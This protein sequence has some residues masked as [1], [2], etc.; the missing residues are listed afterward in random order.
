MINP[1]KITIK[2][3]KELLAPYG[4]ELSAW[5]FAKGGEVNVNLIVS[6][7][8]KKYFVKIAVYRNDNDARFQVEL[9]EYL[10][11]KKFSLPKLLRTKTGK[12]FVYFKKKPVFVYEFIE[13]KNINLNDARNRRLV[14]ADIIKMQKLLKDFKPKH[15]FVKHVN[16]IEHERKWLKR[17]NK[18]YLFKPWDEMEAELGTINYSELREQVIHGDLQS[19]NILIDKKGKLW[20]IDFDEARLDYLLYDVVVFITQSI[21][22]GRGISLK[23]A[24]EYIQFFQK[25]YKLSN[26]DFNIIRIMANRRLFTKIIFFENKIYKGLGDKAQNKRNLSLTQDRYQDFVQKQHLFSLLNKN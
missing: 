13:G 22:H 26:K 5:C 10:H 9:N 24:Q 23:R 18:K 17:I 2:D 14:L 4:I 8:E 19:Q 7:K 1:S 15:L 12:F 16:E 20:F 3:V 11:Q 25:Q 21:E 6:A